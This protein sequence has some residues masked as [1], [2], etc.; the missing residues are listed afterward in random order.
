[1][2]VAPSSVVITSEEVI[3]EEFWVPQPAKL[4]KRRIL[5]ALKTGSAVLG[6]EIAD[7]KVT[8]AIRTK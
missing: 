5:E 4:D 1:V 7:T 3:P 8:L 2:R 6:A